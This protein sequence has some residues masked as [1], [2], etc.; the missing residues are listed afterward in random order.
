VSEYIEENGDMCLKVRTDHSNPDGIGCG[1]EYDPTLTDSLR[2]NLA[3]ILSN[4]LTT[5]TKVKRMKLNDSLNF[6]VGG[7]TTGTFNV[8]LQLLMKSGRVRGN[9]AVKYWKFCIHKKTH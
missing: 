3:I 9:S 5:D 6:D 4:T 7:N 2:N 1:F 8:N